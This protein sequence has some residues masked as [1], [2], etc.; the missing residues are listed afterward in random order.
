MPTAP[1]GLGRRN[2]G[3]AGRS[4]GSRTVGAA[5]EA[6]R[7]AASPDDVTVPFEIARPSRRECYGFEGRA[8][9]VRA[10]RR[11]RAKELA[12]H[13]AATPVMREAPALLRPI[14]HISRRFRSRGAPLPTPLPRRS[15][16][17]GCAGAGSRVRLC[18]WSSGVTYSPRKG[19]MRGLS[20]RCRSSSPSPM[21]PS[22]RCRWSSVSSSY[23]SGLGRDR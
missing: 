15:S 11:T 14:T 16:Q 18:R 10:C 21:S 17:I 6:I 7:R 4:T 5:D 20:D 2:G 1:S 8:S 19:S 22:P 3:A 23:S 9:T 12:A 13:R